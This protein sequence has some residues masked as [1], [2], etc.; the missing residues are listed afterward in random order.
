[1]WASVLLVF[2]MMDRSK[3]K[4]YHAVLPRQDPDLKPLDPYQANE[5]QGGFLNTC[6]L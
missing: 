1:M 4:V 6:Y 3:S 2:E 5:R